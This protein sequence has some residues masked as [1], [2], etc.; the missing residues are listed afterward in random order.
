MPKFTTPDAISTTIE[1]A[2]G[3][4]QLVAGDRTDTVV[5]VRPT[6]PSDASDVEAA[7]ATRVDYTDGALSVVG[8]ESRKVD[9]SHKTRSVDVVVEL[10]VGSRLTAD[11]AAG[12]CSSTGVLGDAR[13]QISAGNICLYRTGSLYADTTAGAIDVEEIGGDAEI[14][15]GSGTVRVAAIGGNAVVKNANGD[16]SLGAVDGELRVRSSNG[17]ISVDRAGVHVEVKTAYGDI[18]VDRIE[19]GQ[20]DLT[21]SFGS[22]DIG[23]SEGTAAWLNVKT[24]FGRVENALKS[25][26]GP[27]KSEGTAKVHAYTSHGDV[28][29]RRA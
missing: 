21:T 12:D 19:R 13:V 1:L 5:E 4:V 24:G 10:P 27:Q 15:T 28:T 18:R 6:N 2:V 22:I 20:V 26:A 16:T 9:F 14:A 8:P 3:Q 25:G 17:A 29:V 7:E 11:I 23:I